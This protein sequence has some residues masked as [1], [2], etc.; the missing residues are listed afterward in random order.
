MSQSSLRHLVIDLVLAELPALTEF[1][2]SCGNS[3]RRPGIAVVIGEQG[4]LI[5]ERAAGT[6]VR[7]RIA[8]R[9]TWVALLN[10]SVPG[11][12]CVPI[13]LPNVRLLF[14]HADCHAGF[15]TGRSAWRRERRTTPMAA[16]RKR[17][18][19]LR[20]ERD[21]MAQQELA[22]RGGCPRQT[23]PRPG[24]G[25]DRASSSSGH[26]DRSGVRPRRAGHV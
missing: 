1:V 17:I 13:L 19:R 20:F 14:L 11:S 18:R 21:E 8:S 25:E 10:E 2:A 22:E 6:Q 24:A 15:G 5:S 23:K 7:A 26:S 9:A 4:D 12:I 3:W 16:I